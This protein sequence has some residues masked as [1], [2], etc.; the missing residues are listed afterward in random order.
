MS[1]QDI[2]TRVMQALKTVNDP[3]LHKNI[4]DLGFVKNM[5]IDGGNVSFDVEL[6]T[7][8]CP[9]KEQLKNECQEKVSALEGVNSVTVNMTAAV[10]AT[11]HT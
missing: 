11:E 7:P 4:V 6:T 2:Q 10:R 5:K 8:A 9:V 1:E 3:D